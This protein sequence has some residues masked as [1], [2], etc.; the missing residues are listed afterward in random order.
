MGEVC[1]RFKILFPLAISHP[2]R[3]KALLESIV[4]KYHHV[5]YVTIRLVNTVHISK[6]FKQG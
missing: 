4:T 5:V 1:S 6:H 3:I 2:F